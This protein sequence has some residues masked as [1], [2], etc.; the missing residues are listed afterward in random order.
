MTVYFISDTH[1]DDPDILDE[2]PRDF[3]DI[4]DMNQLI[5]QNWN[6][7]VD[8]SDSVLF[9]GDLAHSD[10]DKQEFYRWAHRVNGIEIMLRGNHDPYSRS[11]LS[12]ATL[13]IEE[14]YE[15]S[16]NGLDFYCSHKYS[17]I[18][19]EFNGWKIHGHTHQKDPFLDFEAKRINVSVDVLGYEPIS[20]SELTTY[21]E[22]D[23]NLSKRPQ[24]SM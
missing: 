20:L 6:N 13:Q 22:Q 2:S 21:I 12:D 16:H 1:F 15:F 24:S 14:S 5:L 8:E 19:E 17:G 4:T 23:I 11:E 10:A 9:G 18:P 7:T 3:D